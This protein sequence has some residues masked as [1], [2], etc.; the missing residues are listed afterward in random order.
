MMLRL[1]SLSAGLIALVG[2]VGAAVAADLGTPSYTPSPGPVVSGFNWTGP[3]IGALLG[4]GFGQ[5]KIGS[6]KA[7]ADGVSGGGYAG[8]NFAIS[9]FLLGVEGDITGSAMSGGNSGFTVSNPWNGT[10]R[11]RAGV[12]VDRFLLYGTGGF[13]FGEEKVSNAASSDSSM[14]G[15]WTAGLG[16]EA[17][18]TNNVTARVEYR[19][20]D[21][22]S[23]TFATAPN[24][25]VDFTSNQ[26]FAG[27][28]M[29]F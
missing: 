2:S 28:G 12:T 11:A 3:E 8:Y 27:V 19:Y 14:R 9:N 25:S 29:K 10:L 21:L 6:A 7:N 20:T 15:G 16:A 26:I 13:A 5:S 4:Y 24:T 22:G 1:R 18:I 17:A 23:H